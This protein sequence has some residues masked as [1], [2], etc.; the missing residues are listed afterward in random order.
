MDVTSGQMVF[1]RQHLKQK[2]NNRD[3]ERSRQLPDALAIETHPM[4]QTVDGPISSWER[5]GSQSN[6]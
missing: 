1:E 3:V 6:A 5:V 2:L 4:F